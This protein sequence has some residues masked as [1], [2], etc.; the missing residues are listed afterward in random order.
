MIFYNEL[1]FYTDRRLKTIFYFTITKV[2]YLKYA[3]VSV[4]INFLI[5]ISLVSAV[6]V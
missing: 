3:K 1:Q 5:W 6:A 4:A 2:K